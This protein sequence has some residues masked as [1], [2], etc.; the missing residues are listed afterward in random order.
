MS[1]NKISSG[2]S[3]A[4][5]ENTGGI[6]RAFIANFEDVS[7]FTISGT[8]SKVDAITMVAGSPTPVYYEYNFEKTTGELNVSSEI[9]I[10]NGTK[11]FTGTLKLKFFKN[12]QANFN[13]LESLAYNPASII[14]EDLNGKYILLGM[15]NN[16]SVS[17]INVA[18]GV[19]L[20]DFNGQEIEWTF[21]EKSLPKEL[22]SES[23]I[24]AVI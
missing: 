5:L 1:C 16:C 8:T 6:R 24:T 13:Q 9:N 21:S 20:G 10:Q 11:G 19:G 17:A 22:L 14:V 2:R 15:L 3:F 4:C 23:V 12:E 7:A 18:W